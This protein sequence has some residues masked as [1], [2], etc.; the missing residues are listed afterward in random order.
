MIIAIDI[1][2]TL[3]DIHSVWL[4]KYNRISGDDMQVKDITKYYF[5]DL[6]KPAYQNVIGSMRTPDLYDRVRPVSGSIEAIINLS[7]Y[8]HHLVCLSR[9][10]RR[11]AQA[12]RR[13]ITK[14][15]PIDDIVFCKDKQAVL[16]YDVLIDDSPYN[17]PDIFLKQPW[18]DGR[19]TWSDVAYLVSSAQYYK[20]M[21]YENR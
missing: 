14:Y 12:K 11:F 19:S 21:N 7:R 3:L 4:E 17:K 8:G 10:S 18:N 16:K 13:A 5:Y 9:D 1:D 6:V 2:G 20:E 15:F